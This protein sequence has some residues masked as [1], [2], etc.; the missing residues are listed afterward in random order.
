MCEQASHVAT[1]SV[2]GVKSDLLDS[3]V[4]WLD[5]VSELIKSDTKVESKTAATS[6]GGGIL[7]DPFDADWAALATRS[8]PDPVQPTKNPFHTGSTAGKETIQKAF[9]LQM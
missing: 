7:D 4:N 6:S 8:F 9:E 1:S 3:S 5:Q 2:N